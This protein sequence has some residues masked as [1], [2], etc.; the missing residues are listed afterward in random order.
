M[1]K[2]TEE[3]GGRKGRIRR[4]EGWITKGKYESREKGKRGRIRG[5]RKYTMMK[6]GG[7]HT[8]KS[9]GRKKHQIYDFCIRR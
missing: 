4:N 3:I 7:N 9:R 1:V 2:S 8:Q 5:N 6:L